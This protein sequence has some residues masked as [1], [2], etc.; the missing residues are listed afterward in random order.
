MISSEHYDSLGLWFTAKT[1]WSED[2]TEMIYESWSRAGD[3]L[4]KDKD[5]LKYNF[6]A[7]GSVKQM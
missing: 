1:Q 4:E 6:Y 7:D 2:R 3:N 5:I